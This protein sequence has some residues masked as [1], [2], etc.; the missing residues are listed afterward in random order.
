MAV[1]VL[2]VD[3]APAV[4]SVDLAQTL[5]EGVG[6]VV[7]ATRANAFEDR[8]EVCLVDQESVVL[9][10][11]SRSTH[12]KEVEGRAVL[13]FDPPERGKLTG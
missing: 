7:K 9:G 6:P 1:G 12:F 11:D 2:E 4:V 5:L 8:I 13:E 3:T 10:G